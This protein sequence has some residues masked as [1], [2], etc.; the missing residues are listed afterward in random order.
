MEKDWNIVFRFHKGSNDI[1]FEEWDIIKKQ[2]EG[3]EDLLEMSIFLSRYAY[4]P[5]DLANEHLGVFAPEK[6]R[7][8]AICEE[9]MHLYDSFFSFLC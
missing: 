5:A 7:K 4:S 1:S 9:D 2:I 3:N 6:I 8:E